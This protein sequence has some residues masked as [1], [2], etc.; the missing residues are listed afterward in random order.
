MDNIFELDKLLSSLTL[1]EDKKAAALRFLDTSDRNQDP[2]LC[3][4]LP[5][6]NTP[7]DPRIAELDKESKSFHDVLQKHGLDYGSILENSTSAAQGASRTRG[8]KYPPPIG[9]IS[10]ANYNLR[11][12]RFCNKAGTRACSEC[13]L[14]KYCGHACQMQ[15]WRQHKRDCNN[16]LNSEIWKPDWIL[17]G[18][19]PSFITATES[20][21]QFGFGMILWGNMPAV[22]ILNLAHNEGLDSAR[23]F[24]LLFAACG[25]LR[26][27]IRTVNELPDDYSGEL[28]IVLNDFNPF[29]MARNLIIL[30]ILTTIE[31]LDTETACEHALHLWYSIFQPQSY[32]NDVAYHITRQITKLIPNPD[33]P[34]KLTATS[35]LQCHFDRETWGVLGK[36]IVNSDL[37]PTD[38]SNAF[39]AVM[40]TPERVDY[41]H[42]Y[43]AKLKPSH[44]LAAARW[45]AH[46][47]VL[48]FGEVNAHHN[49]PNSWFFHQDERGQINLNFSDQAN[50]LHGW[51]LESILEAGK[52]HGVPESDILGAGFFYIKDQL[53]EFAR[54]LRRFKVKFT[55]FDDNALILPKVMASEPLVPKAFDR[56]EVSNIVDVNYCK[57]APVLD[58]F[59]P[60]LRST[61]PHAT[62]VG[63]FMNWTLEKPTSG[64]AASGLSPK[65]KFSRSLDRMDKQ[66]PG[67][68]KDLL[69]R[70]AKNMMGSLRP[71]IDENISHIMH[72]IDAFHDSSREFLEFLG[73]FGAPKAARK[74][75]LRMR[76]INTIVPPRL[77][78]PLGSRF[79]AVVEVK[80][81]EHWYL[82]ATVDGCTF[83]ERYVE[84]H[85]AA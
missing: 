73:R 28:S 3:T 69:M 18:R 31:T 41:A 7:K 50:P 25:D 16:I 66:L 30:L 63:L 19:I 79:D 46:G 45:R 71:T 48:P 36:N 24:S 57:V 6:A 60:L 44:R 49:I 55:L 4:L 27:V 8:S 81:E 77:Y 17:E 52:A 20:H 23:D 34:L 59:G 74:A 14:V 80:D 2:R 65:D 83:N 40:N 62:L 38:A 53:M 42:R 11:E 70:S 15:H 5:S 12:R 75:G 1:H 54:R 33:V 82:M 13:K 39:N 26:N 35:T 9:I 22:D 10:C 84:W 76:Q 47:L 21:T 78:A 32:I 67:F 64:S 51:D 37:Q 58:T 61:N 56:I 68:S 85:R 29:I 72:N 43:Y